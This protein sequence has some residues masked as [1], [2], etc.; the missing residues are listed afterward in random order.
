MEELQGIIDGLLD[1]L[2]VSKAHSKIDLWIEA[3]ASHDDGIQIVYFALKSSINEHDD[4]CWSDDTCWSK[5][6]AIYILEN[7][8]DADWSSIH[9]GQDD[10]EVIW[11]FLVDDKAIE[12]INQQKDYLWIKRRLTDLYGDELELIDPEEAKDY[13]ALLTYGEGMWQL[14][15]GGQWRNPS[16]M[17]RKMMNLE[18]NFS[19][20]EFVASKVKR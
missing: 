7:L 11:S 15:N 18:N 10:M 2:K 8:P 9:K 5:K 3:L 19:L 1:R 12:K 16:E 6:H 4:D 13:I 17:Q 20:I 14:I